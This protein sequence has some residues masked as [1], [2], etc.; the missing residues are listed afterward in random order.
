MIAVLLVGTKWV[1][2]KVTPWYWLIAHVAVL[3][4][5]ARELGALSGGDGLVT[6]ARLIAWPGR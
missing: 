6:A 4:W 5:L 2:P 3:A 1:A